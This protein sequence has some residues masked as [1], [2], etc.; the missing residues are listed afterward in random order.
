[1]NAYSINLAFTTNRALSDIELET[2]RSQ[3]IAQI[4]EPVT[5][6]GDDVDYITNL[7]E[8]NK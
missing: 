5:A 7:I 8:E 2:L 1:M 3:L 4:E 6:D